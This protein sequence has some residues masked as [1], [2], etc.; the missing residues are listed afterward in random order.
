MR[1]ALR[2][3][4]PRS[5]HAV[6]IAGGAGERFWPASRAKRP[7]PFLEVVDG[8]SLLDATLRR[9]RRFAG[10][11]RIWAV[12][13]RDHATAIRR[14]AKLPAARMLVEPMRRDTAMA[15]GLAAAWIHRDDPDAVLA[16]VISRGR[17]MVDRAP[18]P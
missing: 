1:R 12:C 9:A 15:V 5:I 8:R 10:R 3:A 14:A 17:V 16:T 13:G 18:T 4:G 11:D 7:K 6:I 2:G